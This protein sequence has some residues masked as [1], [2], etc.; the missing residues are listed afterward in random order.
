MR[1]GRGKP[2]RLALRDYMSK[3][4][5]KRA[6]KIVGGQAELARRIGSKQQTVWNWLHRNDSGV[7]AEFVSK[8]EIATGGKVTRHQLRPDVFT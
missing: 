4:A 3:K 5:L 2:A 8:I 1:T 7:P 6:I